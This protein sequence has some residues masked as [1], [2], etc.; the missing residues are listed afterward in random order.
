MKLK[1]WLPNFFLQVGFSFKN[2][3]LHFLFFLQEDAQ[4]AWTNTPQ[5]PFSFYVLIEQQVTLISHQEHSPKFKL[6]TTSYC[7]GVDNGWRKPL[8]LES[9]E[10]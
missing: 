4:F 8:R 7:C 6:P 1:Q 10:I 9:E 2:F 5:T 3:I